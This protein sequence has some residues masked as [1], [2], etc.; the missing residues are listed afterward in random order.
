MAGKDYEIGY[1]KPPKSGQFKKGQSGN[2]KGRPRGSKNLKTDLLE[3]LKQTVVIKEAGAARTV[4][5]QRA[6]IK[7][8]A[9]RA[10]N[11]E[12]RSMALF[13]NLLLR[14]ATDNPES[15]EAADLTE[16]DQVILD[17]FIHEATNK[18]PQGTKKGVRD[19]E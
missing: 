12:P 3:E 11:G 15:A 5:K 9:A 14:L 1:G 18:P 17:R 2:P 16:A 4:S 10:I 7:N 13:A 19:D 6:F 8:L